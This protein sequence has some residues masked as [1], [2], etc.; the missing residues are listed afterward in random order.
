MDILKVGFWKIQEEAFW[1]NPGM[2]FLGFLE[3]GGVFPGLPGG[4]GS[5]FNYV[6]N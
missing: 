1:E 4:R 3:A 5:V 2:D 6:F